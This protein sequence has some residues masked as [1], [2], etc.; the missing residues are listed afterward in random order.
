VPYS[1]RSWRTPT[2]PLGGNPPNME[3]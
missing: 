3:S 1:N 2:R